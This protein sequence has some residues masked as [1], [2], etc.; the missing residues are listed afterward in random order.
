[1]GVSRLP[2]RIPQKYSELRPV[3]DLLRTA[4]LEV[5][6]AIA[7]DAA[8]G[9]DG[10]T[11]SLSSLSADVTALETLATAEFKETHFLRGF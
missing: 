3:F 9:L 11:T 8:D 2:L 1:M 5:I 10:V 6:E 4:V 7:G